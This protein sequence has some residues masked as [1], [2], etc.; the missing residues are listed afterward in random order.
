M[1]VDH[2]LRVEEQLVGNATDIIG[3]LRIAVTIGDN[4]LATLLEVEQSL[5]DGMC[6]GWCVSHESTCLEIDTFDVLVVLGLLDGCQNVVQ[7][8][9]LADLSCQF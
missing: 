4:P 6:R 3:G 2:T 5:T 8:Q 1:P 7:S 9:V